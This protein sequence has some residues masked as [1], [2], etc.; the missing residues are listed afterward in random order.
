M[1]KLI[2][3]IG[4]PK[5]GSTSIQNF[6]LQNAKPCIEKIRFELLNEEE[7][8]SLNAIESDMSLLKELNRKL[9]N[10]LKSTDVLIWS[11][12]HFF[13]SPDAIKKVVLSAL[14]LKVDLSI[15][16]YV[17]RQSSFILSSYAQWAFRSA[18]NAEKTSNYLTEQ[19]INPIFFNAFEKN[20][21]VSVLRDFKGFHNKIRYSKPFYNWH[22][23]FLTLEQIVGSSK[24]LKIGLLPTKEMPFDL[25]A[26]FCSKVNLTLKPKYAD[27]S[28]NKSNPKFHPY[29]VE[30]INSAAILQLNPVGLHEKND[31]LAKIS[32]EIKSAHFEHTA[33]TQLLKEYVDQYFWPSNSQLCQKYEL[34]GSY[35]AIS[36]E[37]TAKGML[38]QAI[39]EELQKRKNDPT[40]IVDYYKKV[41]ATLA[42]PCIHF[43]E[44]A[45][46]KPPT[47]YKTMKKI[48]ARLVQRK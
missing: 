48:A 40:S 24:L 29:L 17:R 21:L 19:G 33:F 27:K 14:E 41:A 2:L 26:D 42:L 25:V 36:S 5:C 43:A 6:F 11:H 10:S 34:P 23:T 35:F 12:E 37:S 31:L 32:G 15:V 38:R 46:K 13:V 16:A 28:S 39:E 3:H 18:G 20:L 30:A 1:K 4:A 45:D 22:N 9:R 47:P 8:R 7:V 44:M